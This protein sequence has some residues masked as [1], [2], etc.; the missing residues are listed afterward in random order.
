MDFSKEMALQISHDF[1][2]LT[3]KHT[4]MNPLLNE[5]VEKIKNYTDCAAVGI[6]RLKRS[7]MRR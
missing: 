3:N 5:F 6:I 7:G 2:K 1:L 4:I